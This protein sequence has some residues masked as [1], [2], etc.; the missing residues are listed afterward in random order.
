MLEKTEQYRAF[1]YCDPEQDSVEFLLVESDKENNRITCT[2]YDSSLEKT[3]EAVLN[4]ESKSAFGV[5]QQDFSISEL[6]NSQE[7][8]NS[9]DKV[10]NAPIFK[11]I[12]AD[13]LHSDIMDK[14]ALKIGHDVMGNE[15]FDK[16]DKI[17]TVYD[18]SNDNVTFRQSFNDISELDL[19]S[20][21]NAAE[22]WDRCEVA[23]KE[24]VLFKGDVTDSFREDVREGLDELE[25]A[26]QESDERVLGDREL[27]PL[28]NADLATQIADLIYAHDDDLMDISLDD[29]Q[30]VL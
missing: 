17:I 10:P 22:G 16:G 9:S 26:G 6:L 29:I 27:E 28:S 3:S 7:Y 23:N 11:P 14:Q 30:A 24:G 19:F 21:Q 25:A 15:G 4:Y 5:V 13:E 8:R 1:E 2:Y 20:L 12:N 18:K